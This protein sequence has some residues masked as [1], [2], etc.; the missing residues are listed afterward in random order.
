[1]D[2][3]E[4]NYKFLERYSLPRLN[5]EKKKKDNMSRLI[6]ST[7]METM[8]QNEK[9]PGPEWKATSKTWWLYMKILS[10]I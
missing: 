10:N 3:L 7:E 9:S 8:I 4:K 6:K 2:N 5:Q 1:M